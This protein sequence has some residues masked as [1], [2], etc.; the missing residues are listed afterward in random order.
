M[1]VARRDPLTGLLDRR[2]FQTAF[3]VELERARRSRTPL[4]LVVLDVD[5]FARVN[6][7]H[8]RGAGDALLRR[9]GRTLEQAKRGFDRAARVG[10]EE[11]AVLIP[12]S[13]EDGAYCFAERVRASCDDGERPSVTASFGI[14]TFPQHGQSMS[15]LLQA[16]D[17]ALYAAQ[18]GG[19]DRTVIS[20]AEVP[21]VLAAS[22]RPRGEGA[23]ELSA[24]L[25]LAE[26]LDLREHGSASHSRRV[27]RF[28]EL[29]ARELGLPP[30]G[31]ERVR[32]AGVL[33]DVGRVGLPDELVRKPGPLTTRSGA[34]ARASRRSAS[35]CSPRRASTTSAAGSGSTTS[36]PTGAA[37][38]PARRGSGCRWRRASSPS[39][40][41]TRR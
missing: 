4:S 31:V 8:G 18:R 24:L 17:Q 28:A 21:G 25:Q 33:H 9:I 23:V 38:R 32:L 10:G 12:D 29:T 37:T 36:G 35:G 26:A 15:A 27:A 2:G 16:A 22:A 1:A 3:D 13:G 11:F 39:R 5:R 7:R 41:P 19:R 14:A 30:E 20:S 34:G 6:E 40:T